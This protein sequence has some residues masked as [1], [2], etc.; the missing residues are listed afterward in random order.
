ML[1]RYAK[2]IVKGGFKYE[3]QHGCR[4]ARHYLRGAGHDYV[5]GFADAVV[6]A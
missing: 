6:A 5:E 2:G 3:G 1:V 4:S